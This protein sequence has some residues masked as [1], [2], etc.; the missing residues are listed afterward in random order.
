M[1]EISLKPLLSADWPVGSSET[2]RLLSTVCVCLSSRWVIWIPVT[3]L[4]LSTTGACS[5]AMFWW[6]I[7]ITL[8]SRWGFKVSPSLLRAFLRGADPVPNGPALTGTG[9]PWLALSGTSLVTWCLLQTEILLVWSGR[10]WA[11]NQSRSKTARNCSTTVKLCSVTFCGWLITRPAPV[12]YV[13]SL[14]VQFRLPVRKTRISVRNEKICKFL[15]LHFAQF[16]S[17]LHCN[18]K[19]ELAFY[20]KQAE[21]TNRRKL[22]IESV[23]GLTIIC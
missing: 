2:S 13:N 21:W 1:L 23:F 22:S 15:K 9:P 16:C 10:A 18:E 11:E 7:L 17:D 20:N 19:E 4:G 5:L 8:S 3:S 6:L 14:P 12:L